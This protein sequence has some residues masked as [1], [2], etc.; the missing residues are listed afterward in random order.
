MQH[1]SRSVYSDDNSDSE[2]AQS[3]SVDGLGEVDAAMYQRWLRKVPIACTPMLESAIW[4]NNKSTGPS[5]VARADE[6]Y[7]DDFED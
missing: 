4:A 6:E 1:L 3:E 7:E 2:D 5:W